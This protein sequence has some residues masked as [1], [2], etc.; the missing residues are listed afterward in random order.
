MGEL[1]FVHLA[2]ERIPDPL[3]PVSDT[4]TSQVKGKASTVAVGM[5][6]RLR[7]PV[8]VERRKRNKGET[9]LMKRLEESVTRAESD[10]KLLRE[11]LE[12]I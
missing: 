1:R 3:G 12:R 2:A 7:R 5:P 6:P 8:S 9:E 4:T 10:L 11:I